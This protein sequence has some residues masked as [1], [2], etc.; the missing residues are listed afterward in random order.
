MLHQIKGCVAMFHK[1]FSRI[2]GLVFFLTLVANCLAMEEGKPAPVFTATLLDGKTVD[3]NTLK[4]QVVI[5]HFWATWCETCRE[6]MPALDAYYRLHQP[7]GLRVIAI[8]MDDK[9]QDA[10]VQHVMQDYRFSAAHE[11]DSNYKGF[12]RIWAMPMTFVI[13]RDGI[14]RK[15]GSAQPWIMDQNALESIVSPLLKPK[16]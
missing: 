10:A 7:E 1:Y 9:K 15:D 12:G 5:L 16:S 6:E 8:S 11:R 13:D 14:L 2:A 3:S 4:G